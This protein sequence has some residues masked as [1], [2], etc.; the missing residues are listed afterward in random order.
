MQLPA[1]QVTR[2]NTPGWAARANCRE[3]GGATFSS[4]CRSLQAP[5]AW[6]PRG[7]GLTFRLVG[8]R[9]EWGRSPR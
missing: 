8:G 6:G 3:A 9:T 5:M 2:V 1:G 7:V 4:T